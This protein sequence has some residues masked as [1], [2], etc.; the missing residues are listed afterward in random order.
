MKSVIKVISICFLSIISLNAN[1]I[2]VL[3]INGSFGITGAL[4]TTPTAPSDLTA[5]SAIALS[6]VFGS[7]TGSNDTSNVTFFSTGS[8]GAAENLTGS[9]TGNNFFSIEGWNFQL[10]SLTVID[11][12]STLLS[13]K[14]NGILS[15]TNYLDTNATWSF[16][17]ASLSSYNM[18]IQTVPVPAA[19]WLFGSGLLGLVGIA[20]RRTA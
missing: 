14:G 9:L 15:G 13:L 2:S 3:P 6:T 10:T 1:A 19:V 4:T 16:S 12:T 18:S 8:G 17:T 20:R 7:Y 11:Q 5:V